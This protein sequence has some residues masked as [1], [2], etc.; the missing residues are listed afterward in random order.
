MLSKKNIFSYLYFALICLLCRFT[1]Y[2]QNN[3]GEKVNP[4]IIQAKAGFKYDFTNFSSK[5]GLPISSAYDIIQI[6]NGTYWIASDL[7]VSI[8]DGKKFE[9]FKTLGE[10]PIWCLLQ[11]TKGNV[12]M[13]GNNG[14]FKYDGLKLTTYDDTMHIGKSAVVDIIESTDGKIWMAAYRT[15]LI[16]IDN[17]KISVFNSC[18][19]RKIKLVYSVYED[20]NG[21]IWIGDKTG[22]YKLINNML[23]AFNTNELKD[24]RSII[25][26]SRGDMWFGV[27]GKGIYRYKENNF[28]IYSDKNGYIK[29]NTIWGAIEDNDKNIWFSTDEGLVVYNGTYFNCVTENEG[30]INNRTWSVKK[31]KLGRLLIASYGGGISIYNGPKFRYADSQTGFT[32]KR[33]NHTLKDSK[34]NY[35]FCTEGDGI[36]KYDGTDFTKY[37]FKNSTPENLIWSAYEDN[38]KELW[39]CTDAGLLNYNGKY[40]TR[41]STKQ[42]AS[43]NYFWSVIKDDTS[44]LWIGTYDKG[45][46]KF[47]GKNFSRSG[48]VNKK[49]KNQRALQ[50]LKDKSGNIWIHA[51]IKLAVVKPNKDVVILDTINGLLDNSVNHIYEDKHGRIWLT[52]NRGLSVFSNPNDLS[53]CLTIPRNKNNIPDVT[54][55]TTECVSDSE[56]WIGTNKGVITFNYELNNIEIKPTEPIIFYNQLN[57]FKDIECVG[58]SS[59]Y[60]L[61]KNHWFGTPSGITIVSGEKER[62][63]KPDVRI[64]GI[65]FFYQPVNW[66]KNKNVLSD[67]LEPW[68]TVPRNFSCTYKNNHITFRFLGSNVKTLDDINYRFKLEGFDEDWSNPSKRNDVTYSNLPHGNYVFKVKSINEFNQESDVAVVSF[69]IEPPFWNTWWFRVTVSCTIFILLFGVFRFRTNALLKRKKELEQIVETRTAELKEQK[70]IAE[71]QTEIVQQKNKEITDSINYAQRIQRSL[72]ANTKLLNEGLNMQNNGSYFILFKPKDIVSGDF[73]WA[74]KNDNYFYLAVCDS[75]GH[76][77]PGAIMSMLNMA[78]LNESISKG[79]QQPDLI[80]NETRSRI[81]EHLS[82]NDVGEVGK[83]GMDCSLLRFD[84]KNNELSVASANNPIWIVRKNTSSKTELIEIPPDKMPV[85]QHDKQNIPFTSKNIKLQSGDTIYSFTDGFAD[86]FGGPKGKK[87]KYK[88]LQEAILSIQTNDMP[89]QKEILLQQFN[90]WK[91]QLEQID[92]VLI[93]GIKL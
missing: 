79:I 21:T 40:F 34:N 4:S 50:L 9:S 69:F 29:N 89:E 65:D 24:T 1:S 54:F 61:E 64:T 41:F 90:K 82:N 35:W 11:D 47:D 44:A 70:N 37:Y 93:I 91:G 26:D 78:C 73:Y 15:G 75:T 52:S 59:Y 17:D 36:I 42:G 38:N 71:I 20:K 14:A 3:I 58:Y 2:S 39:F 67:T 6:N 72:L 43:T 57:G 33:I 25:R 92:D 66:K 85:G 56:L 76:G 60:S 12:W 10:K 83:D 87:F 8:Y 77:V 13:G 5:Q 80:L 19:D 32:D 55:L 51:D 23:E 7:G 68:K 86:Q 81:I 28:E 46:V 63:T 74:A 31:D 16:C 84:F 30:L 88:Q 48:G 45:I 27:Y 49:I 62:F 22:V 53:R 18:N